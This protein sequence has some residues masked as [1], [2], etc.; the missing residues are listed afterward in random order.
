MHL[1]YQAHENK[2]GAIAWNNNLLTTACKDSTIKIRDVRQKQDMQTLNFHKDVKLKQKKT[3][4]YI[5]LYV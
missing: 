1:E 4:I 2:V 5:L 3:Y